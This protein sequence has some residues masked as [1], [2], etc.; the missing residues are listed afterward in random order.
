MA[1][2]ETLHY[3]QRNGESMKADDGTLYDYNL[4]CPASVKGSFNIVSL[5]IASDG[6]FSGWLEIEGQYRKYR[7]GLNEILIRPA[8][9]Q[10]RNLDHFAGVLGKFDPYAFCLAK[11]IKITELSHTAL[12][13]IKGN[14]PQYEG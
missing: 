2:N 12:S 3:I 4:N 5:D 11:P 7:A 1:S 9:M 13:R 14:F 6:D 10:Y 8:D